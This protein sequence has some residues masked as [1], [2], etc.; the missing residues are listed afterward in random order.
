M[1]RKYGLDEKSWE[2]AQAALLLAKRLG[3]IEDAGMEALER[4]RQQKNEKNRQAE[5]AGEMFYGP[6][7]YSAPMYLQYELTRFRLDFVQP[8]EQIRKLGVCP[9][10][11]DEEKRN[12]YER[13]QDLFGRYNGDLFSYEEVSQIIEK[14]LREEAYDKLIQNIL[15]QPDDRQ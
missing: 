5:E 7:F 3:L 8:S 13:N 6:R 14:R 12:F 2:E 15:C 10:F 11:S 9:T 1:N 4:R